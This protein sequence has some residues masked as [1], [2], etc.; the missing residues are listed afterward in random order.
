MMPD[1]DEQNQS[2]FKL[3]L[4]R[5]QMLVK[6]GLQY[7]DAGRDGIRGQQPSRLVL[8]TTLSLAMAHFASAAQDW[9][10]LH[11]CFD[12]RGR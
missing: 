9:V 11:A 3:Y 6:K 1:S 2:M 10:M 7:M 4:Q 12:R 8:E 5:Y